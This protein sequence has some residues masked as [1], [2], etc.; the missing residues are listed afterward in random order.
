MA[1]RDVNMSFGGFQLRVKAAG[2]R[3]RTVRSR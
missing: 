2:Y 1:R 3:L